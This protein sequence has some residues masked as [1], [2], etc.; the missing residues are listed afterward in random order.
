MLVLS[1]K[2]N[3]SINIGD[4]V[5]ITVLSV[6][7]GRVKLGIKAPTDVPVRRC[8]VEL[9]IADPVPQNLDQ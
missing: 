8:E 4:N 5:E 7:G 2:R 9:P 1:R 3:E 6:Q